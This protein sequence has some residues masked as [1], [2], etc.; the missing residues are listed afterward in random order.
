ME[1]TKPGSERLL[2]AP[3]FFGGRPPF[4]SG[5]ARGVFV[6]LREEHTRAHMTRALLEGFCYVMRQNLE[7]LEKTEKKSVDCIT[8][9]GGGSNNR[10]WMQA[11]ADILKIQIRVPRDTG[12]VG[13]VG[14]AQC[15]LLGLGVRKN[16]E[17]VKSGILIQQIYNPNPENFQ[18]YDLL[19]SQFQQLYG[20]M[21]RIF[22]R[23]N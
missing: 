4:S 12:N 1:N 9:C 21:A 5:K 19:Y 14:V 18:E 2:I 11:M 23:L 15:A 17:A 16:Y 3:W 22:E 8:V 7:V 10:Y 20:A 6:N 13:A